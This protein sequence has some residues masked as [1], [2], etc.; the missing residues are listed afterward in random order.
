MTG[1]RYGLIYICRSVNFEPSDQ[2]DLNK[3]RRLDLNGG[4]KPTF[5]P[6]GPTW[7]PLIAMSVLHRLKDCISTVYSSRFDPKAQD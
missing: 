6:A 7:Q 4:G 1:R 2:T 5:E 3:R